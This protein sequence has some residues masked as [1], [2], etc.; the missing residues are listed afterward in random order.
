MPLPPTIADGSVTLTFGAAGQYYGYCTL[1]DVSFE[2]PD[3]S[4]YTTLTN[5]TIGQEIT[6][7]AGEIQDLLATRY[8]MPYTGADGGV[9]L[10]LRNLNAKLA[11]ANIIDRYFQASKPNLSPAAAERRS[12]V[13]LVLKDI[14]DGVIQWSGTG[15]GDATTQPEKPSYPLAKGATIMPDPVLGDEFAQTPIFTMGRSRYRRGSVF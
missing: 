6:Y 1:A 8:L 14:L 5:S 2:F 11:T 7:A 4:S 10:T 3:K 9:Q 15:F 12:W 13:E